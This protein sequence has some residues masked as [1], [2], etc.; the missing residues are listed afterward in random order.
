[1][2][3]YSLIIDHFVTDLTATVPKLAHVVVHRYAPQDASA[4]MDDDAKH[5]AIWPLGERPAEVAGVFTMSGIDAA[6]DI[7]VLY[8]E[9]AH[10][11]A[12]RG[13]VDEA[14]AGEMFE[15]IDDVRARFLSNANRSAVGSYNTR[16]LDV[17][18][19]MGGTQG[20]SLV[21]WFIATVRANVPIP[22][23]P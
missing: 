3:V 7:Q 2:S 17:T 16:W 11:E 19:G 1:M 9:S 21:R 20:S 22:Y 10:G 15:L 13:L 5:L 18:L 6:I 4:L 23:S 12:E 8:W 14:A